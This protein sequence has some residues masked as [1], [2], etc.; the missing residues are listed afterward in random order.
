[1]KTRA[2][3]LVALAVAVSACSKNDNGGAT[4]CRANPFACKMGET[5][6]P[7]DGKGNLQCLPSKAYQVRGAECELLPGLAGCGDGLICVTADVPVDASV[8]SQFCAGFCDDAHPCLASERCQ[9]LPL[10]D[11]VGAPTVSACVPSLLRP[12][13][14]GVMPPDMATPPAPKDM[15][16]A[17][18]PKDMAMTPADLT[19]PPPPPDLTAAVD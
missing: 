7:V 12:D 18:P 16:V 9:K 15:A 8:A 17:P 14:A 10:A 1:M 5:C 11:A 13:M 19:T 6:W 4:D 2:F 3:V